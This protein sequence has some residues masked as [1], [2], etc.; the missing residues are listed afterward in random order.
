MTGYFQGAITSGT[1]P[2]QSSNTGVAVLEQSVT[3]TT[4]SAGTAVSGTITLPA[5]SQILNFTVDR[6][7]AQ[8]VGGG[9]A[10]A[11]AAT[12]GTAAAGTQYMSSTAAVSSSR[13]A[14]TLTV[15]QLN[16]MSN[17]GSN[18][19]VVLTIT[20]DGTILTTQGQF[21]L[22]VTYVPPLT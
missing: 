4:V 21:L 17:I 16:A 13:L 12:V 11:I 18:T 14:P 5:N 2:S 3:V 1:G 10:T 8:S 9:T 22:T 15:A 20:P 7:V 19:N 6:I